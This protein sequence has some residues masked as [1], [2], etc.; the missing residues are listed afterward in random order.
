MF[1]GFLFY[2][3]I[4]FEI[5]AITAVLF[6]LAKVKSDALGSG[7]KWAAYILLFCGFLVLAGT[8]TRGIIGMVHHRGEMWHER[9]MMMHHGWMRGGDCYCDDDDEKCEMKG[10]KGCCM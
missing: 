4:C 7:F 3:G 5:I 8:V 6:F 10:G 1:T 9:G 2:F